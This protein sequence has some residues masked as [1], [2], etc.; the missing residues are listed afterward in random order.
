MFGMSPNG[1]YLLSA[2]ERAREPKYGADCRLSTLFCQEQPR[3]ADIRTQRTAPSSADCNP[4]PLRLATFTDTF[5]RSS[6]QRKLPETTG[7]HYP[8][9][10]TAR[11]DLSKSRT[12]T[13]FIVA[14]DNHSQKCLYL[15]DVFIVPGWSLTRY[16]RPLSLFCHQISPITL[17]KQKSVS[18]FSHEAKIYICRLQSFRVSL[19]VT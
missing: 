11:I 7:H 13:S 19:S 6:G 16:C 1:G 8:H 18:T 5:G 9:L 2:R 12:E 4:S 10:F 14:D 17:R 3:V 15:V